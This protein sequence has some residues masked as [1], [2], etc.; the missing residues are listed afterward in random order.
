MSEFSFQDEK[1]ESKLAHLYLFF[2]NT[3]K[4]L[5][6]HCENKTGFYCLVY[7]ENVVLKNLSK[8]IRIAQ[9]SHSVR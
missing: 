8:N 5:V 4:I 9:F 3:F 7:K 6:H 2:K 1:H